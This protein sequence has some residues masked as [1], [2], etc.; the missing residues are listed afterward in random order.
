MY[1]STNVIILANIFNIV[2]Q[3]EISRRQNKLK[4]FR[5]DIN[6]IGEDVENFIFDIAKEVVSKT[7][8]FFDSD[9]EIDYEDG[10]NEETSDSP[11]QSDEIDQL[12]KSRLKNILKKGNITDTTNTTLTNNNL[13]ER[14]FSKKRY[15]RSPISDAPETID[16]PEEN[17]NQVKTSQCAKDTPKDV[18]LERRHIEDLKEEVKKLYELVI[19]LKDQQKILSQLDDRSDDIESDISKR[20]EQKELLTV[21]EHL[22]NDS[23]SEP[24][25]ENGSVKKVSEDSVPMVQINPAHKEL[26]HLKF[27]IK[28]TM[29]A[30][31][32]THD[33]LVHQK[34]S[35]IALR[36]EL[37]KQKIEINILKIMVTKLFQNLN[38]T[39][40]K[41]KKVKETFDTEVV[42][43]PLYLPN[44]MS[45][46]KKNHGTSKE[47]YDRKYSLDEQKTNIARESD[48]DDISR[49]FNEL[50][51]PKVSDLEMKLMELGV[52]KDKK[53][54]EDNLKKLLIVLETLLERQQT[55]P[56]SNFLP[57]NDNDRLRKLQ[58]VL[59]LMSRPQG[60]IDDNIEDE[61]EKLQSEIDKLKPEKEM[62][63]LDFSEAEREKLRNILNGKGRIGEPKKFEQVTSQD[64]LTMKKRLEQL[65]SDGIKKTNSIK[66]NIDLKSCPPPYPLWY[67]YTRNFDR[68]SPYYSLPY[69][70]NINGYDYDGSDSYNHPDIYKP[71]GY[72]QNYVPYLQFPPYQQNYRSDTGKKNYGDQITES[73]F[74]KP[75]KGQ[76]ET[77]ALNEKNNLFLEPTSEPNVYYGPDT[78]HIKF[79]ED[80]KGGTP[81][82]SGPYYGINEQFGDKTRS[83]EDLKIQMNS[84]QSIINNMNNP[85]LDKRPEDQRL[86]GNLEQQINELKNIVNSL[87]TDNIPFPGYVQPLPYNQQR[88]PASQDHDEH[89]RERSVD[90]KKRSSDSE[91]F[92]DI[93][94]KLKSYFFD[95]NTV[96]AETENRS[97]DS[98]NQ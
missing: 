16:I 73:E 22:N 61:L 58:L 23:I 79:S 87:K 57:S 12:N 72:V 21:L 95:E 91:L 92:D 25:T 15:K 56:N 59:R 14:H 18:A 42:G 98:N 55:K 10:S 83:I 48:L 2:T 50:D 17:T 80:F 8:G 9:Y 32:Q 86:I 93:S 13:E 38:F 11:Q 47:S 89:R 24:V 26:E 85:E 52:D 70:P 4:T 74:P 77:N 3:S 31:N 30:L 20:F 43:S 36:K 65:T 5:N 67:A 35:E 27:D 39:N 90:I 88:N 1:F 46:S 41:D 49:F 96:D 34:N 62:S 82:K 44:H 63:P 60:K 75:A 76:P 28:Q 51:K 97:T 69:P 71:P 29:A 54:R 78:D 40:L 64:F 7:D 33:F 81:E 53:K 37:Q 94:R 45:A 19:L 6:K 68:F 84:L 66:E